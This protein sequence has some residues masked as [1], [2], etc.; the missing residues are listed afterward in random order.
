MIEFGDLLPKIQTDVP[1][2]QSQK[3][4]ER[5]AEVECPAITHRRHRREKLGVASPIVWA[6][7]RGS[8]IEDADGNVFVDLSGAFAVASIGHAH[9][10]VVEAAQKQA[11]TLIH[12]M[13]DLFPSRE[14][15]RLSERLAEIA[16]E[17]LERSIL[18]ISGSDAVEA[19]LKTALIATGKRRVLS[20]GGAYHGMSLGA[21]N[22]SSY[23]DSFREP[24]DGLIGASD[25]RL[26]YPGQPGSP[27][28]DDAQRCL[29][30]VDFLLGNDTSGSASIAALIV[31]PI[32]GRG[33]II[34][35][36]NGFLK[37][38]REIT[39]RHGV[40]LIFD[41]IYTGLGRTGTLFACEHEGVVPDLM[42]IGKSLAGGAPIGA[43]LGSEAAMEGWGRPEG[44][45]IHTSTFLG[46]P[47]VA[48]MALAVLDVLKEE[49]LVARSK[50]EGQYALDW[51]QRE[52]RT[53][54]VVEDVRGAGM[55]IGI[56]LRKRDGTAWAGGAVQAMS[57]VLKEGV[58]I[59]PGG[60]NGDVISL[61]P[62]FNIRREQLDVGLE[63]IARWCQQA[64]A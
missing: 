62:A 35:P 28:G 16:P 32:Q 33:G 25:L 38:L 55:M 9:P 56:A 44:E 6:R 48:S 19:C 13:G 5:L 37:G 12:A 63:A 27:F 51:L 49:D 23:R 61:A 59:A 7:A 36:P 52:L 8:N 26:P 45:A 50:E 22:V 14:K 58:V 40:M 3:W 15:V 17:G 30:Y 46:N 41:E 11:A 10:R 43:C 20:F 21:L 42:A 64:S 24:F 57:D 29:D 54:D 39:T 18:A 60:P 47:L 2:G 1:G 31:E 53:C 34:L 4:V